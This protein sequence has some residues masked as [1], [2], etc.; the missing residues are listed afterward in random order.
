MVF[1]G[2]ELKPGKPHT[3]QF[4]AAPGTLHISHATL[5]IGKS[6][7]RTLVQCNVGN[8]RPIF[9]CSLLPDKTESCPLDLEFEEDD[10]VVFSV[11]GPHSVH[12]SGFYLGNV[13]NSGGYGDADDTDSHGEDVEETQKEKSTDNNTKDEYEVH[14]E[15]IDLE[16]YPPLPAPNSGVVIE[17]ILGG[18][19]VPNENGNNRHPGK[20]D[21]PSNSD[22][23][24]SSQ[25]QIGVSGSA[26]APVL[27][28]E[29][30]YGFPIT[31]SFSRVPTLQKKEANV[32]EKMNKKIANKGK[33]KRKEESDLVSGLKKK[34][35]SVQD[36]DSEGS[37]HGRWEE[38]SKKVT[39][40]PK[41][42]TKSAKK[43]ESQVEGI[44]KMSSKRK[45]TPVK[46][47]TS[48]MQHG[49]IDY[50]DYGEN[51]VGSKIKV[52]WPQDRMFYEGVITY[53]DP[54]KMKHK[55]CYSDG[56]VEILSLSKQRW[57][58]IKEDDVAGG[59]E[60]DL[61]SPEASSDI[62][63]K[64]KVK[65]ES[66]SSA[67]QGKTDAS[68]K[69]AGGVS[70]RKSKSK[71]TKSGSEFNEDVKLSSKSKDDSPKTVHISKF[72]DGIIPNNI[73]VGAS[74]TGD[75]SKERKTRTRPQRTMRMQRY[76]EVMIQEDDANAK[77]T[78]SRL[79]KV[80]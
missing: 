41:S 54:V 63:R 38:S 34:C 67:K 73:D 24:G 56:D 66:D 32:K 35:D 71:A 48:E 59:Q 61:A 55:V 11:L 20:K 14:F 4:D 50:G 77:A 9:I 5:G 30:E 58:F 28:S 13:W 37:L 74:A 42:A 52:Y 43:D 39:T 23:S 25:R 57:Q 29:D 3:H 6:T 10:D 64:K 15:D 17:E 22:D 8:T 46:E 78:R 33:S 44:T 36:G 68:A 21:Q 18:E 69:R 79:K 75:H 80:I 53:F 51:L 26:D 1:W 65:T 70:T 7:K 27:E 19:K 49:A 2:V 16:A 40:S 72:S 60:T 31:S 76:S 45:N 62:H 12:L 47:E